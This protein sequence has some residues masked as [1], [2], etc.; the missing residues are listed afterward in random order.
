MGVPGHVHGDGAASE[1]CPTDEVCL[2][3]EEAFSALVKAP[4][5]VGE[6]HVDTMIAF[7]VLSNLPDNAGLDPMWAELVD[8][9]RGA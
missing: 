5:R 9:D 4:N 7:E 1:S 6:V 3:E 2:S 8:I